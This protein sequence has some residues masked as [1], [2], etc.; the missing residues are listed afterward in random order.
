MFGNHRTIRRATRRS[1]GNSKGHRRGLYLKLLKLGIGLTIAVSTIVVIQLGGPPFPYRLGQIYDRQIRARVRFEVINKAQTARE[2]AKAAELVLPIFANDDSDVEKRRNEMLDLIETISKAETFDQVPAATKVAWQL[3]AGSFPTMRQAVNA[4]VK[5]VELD[6]AINEI[7]NTVRNHGIYDFKKEKP[8]MLRGSEIKVQN[9][10]DDAPVTWNLEQVDIETLLRADSLIAREL[11]KLR[12]PASG[13]EWAELLRRG[14]RELPP[15]LTYDEEATERA[16]QH[17]RNSVKEEKDQYNQDDLLV[18]RDVEITEEHLEPLLREHE[19][20]VATRTSIEVL[21]RTASLTIL[22]LALYALAGYYIFRF[23]PLLAGSP[24]RLALF[25]TVIVGG[26]GLA[27]LLTVIEGQFQSD[28]IP[29]ALAAMTLTI[30]YGQQFGLLIS[31]IFGLL[32]AWM[33]GTGMG[34]FVVLTGG[35]AAAVL[36][37]TRVRSRTKL[38]IVGITAG[39]TYFVLTWATGLWTSQSPDLILRVSV[40]VLVWGVLSGFLM[41]GSLPFLEKL[42]GIV[43]DMN[44]LELSDVSHPLLQELMRTA[45]GTYN[46]SVTVATLAETAAEAIAANALLVRVGSYFHDVGKMLKPH[47][48]IENQTDSVNRHQSLH[49][50]M[51][52]LIIIGHVKDGVELAQEQHLPTVIIDLIEQHHGTTLV[53]YFYRE[54][55]RDALTNWEGEEEVQESSFR[56]PGPRPQTKEACIMMLADSVESAS[57]TLSEP[58]PTRIER[59]VGKLTLSR[60]LDGQFEQCGITLQEIG[61]IKE[62]LIKSLNAIYHGRVKYPEQQTA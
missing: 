4:E 21:K 29:I 60:L 55:A 24:I 5:R 59:L 28:I 32:C 10:D 19:K 15:T 9:R 36:S 42:F 62:S 20:Y 39:L 61:T 50:T 35:T 33:L 48:F 18:P 44:L 49:P 16:R 26:L 41:G 14:I 12:P 58:T 23:E 3:T 47:Y 40:C 38:I 53:E 52:T 2:R 17:A 1:N 7:F 31:F 54:A 22:V 45:P 57:R 34:G 51:S 6:S 27:K 25:G 11:E 37:L 56:Y 43:T 8:K 13:T 30:V 46:H